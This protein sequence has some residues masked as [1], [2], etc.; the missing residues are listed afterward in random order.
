MLFPPDAL[1]FSGGGVKG[2]ALIGA[3]MW[4][5]THFSFKRI[6]VYSGVSIGAAISALLCIGYTPSELL[7]CLLKVPL[8]HLQQIRV[9]GLFESNFGLDSGEYLM[10]FL[11]DL[12]LN[13]GVSP[14]I[15]FGQVQTHLGKQLVI[16]GSCL[17]TASP[18]YFNTLDTPNTPVLTAIRI[19]CSIPFLFHMVKYA[20]QS[21]VDGFLTDSF[22][23]DYT[24]KRFGLDVN[25]VL[26][27]ALL[28][29]Q[30]KVI[31]SFAEYVLAVLALG[32][33]IY[34]DNGIVVMVTS[35][36]VSNANFG[37]TCEDCEKM[38]MHGYQASQ[39]FMAKNRKANSQRR[40]SI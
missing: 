40:K 38:A 24:I 36:S 19:S 21:F 2:F 8:H 39:L 14:D 33:K 27:I 29:Q 26:G 20:G 16:V 17:E 3:A 9:R 5:E 1:V 37:L 25:R 7:E 32:I 22:P 11:I 31:Q 10:A 13:K 18:V 4:F 6:R 30:T 35:P 12:F 15:T 34:P 23:M 28:P